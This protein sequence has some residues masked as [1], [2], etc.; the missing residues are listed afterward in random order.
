MPSS[1]CTGWTARLTGLLPVGDEHFPSN[2]IVTDITGTN[3][4]WLWSKPLTLGDGDT[5]GIELSSRYLNTTTVAKIEV[6]N[7]FGVKV[8]TINLT[9]PASVSWR[10][11]KWTQRFGTECDYGATVIAW[12][13]DPP[14]P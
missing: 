13:Y 3:R 7:S 4:E 2:F 1:T 11:W 9:F 12:S 8:Q 6:F 14:M 10:K 5:I